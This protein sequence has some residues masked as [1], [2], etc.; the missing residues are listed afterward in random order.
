MPLVR[1]YECLCDE[2][3]LRAIQLLTRGPLCVCHLQAALGIPQARVSQHLSYLRERG[4]VENRREGTWMIYSLPAKPSRELSRHLACLQDCSVSDRRFR[5]DLKK[6]R[7][8]RGNCGET[9][10]LPTPAACRSNR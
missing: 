4:M 10:N 2:T 7:V 9:G 8:V 6:L 1:I 3:R 5:A